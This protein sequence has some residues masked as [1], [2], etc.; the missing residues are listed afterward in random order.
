[1]LYEIGA[2]GLKRIDVPENDHKNNLPIGTILQLNGYSNPRYV[3]VKNLGISEK[4][5]SYGATYQA[6]NLTDHTLKQENAF[7]LKHI[8]E[9]KDNRIQMYYLD[10]IMPAAEVLALFEKTTQKEAERAEIQAEAKRI[11]DTKEAKGRELFAKH[12]PETAKALIVAEYEVDDCDLQTDYFATSTQKTVILGWSKHKR[13]LF[14]E[15]RKHADKIPETSHLSTAPAT[16]SNREPKTENNKSWWHPSDEHR[17][18]Y[19]MGHGYYLKATG[20]YSSGWRITKMTKCGDDW[21]RD[22]Y[23]SMA[24]RC[25]FDN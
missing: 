1:M 13:D 15:M 9:K 6:I 19:S 22:I 14:G 7:G 18:K 2:N 4:F 21:G 23:I 11:S 8:D 5:P 3:I 20:R 10:E 12:I 25:V 17:E 16:N 24:E